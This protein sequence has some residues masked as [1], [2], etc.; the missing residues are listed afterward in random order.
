MNPNISCRK[1]NE[2]TSSR[3]L[4]QQNAAAKGTNS[5]NRVE[6]KG[7]QKREAFID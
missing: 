3:A 1:I 2:G 6:A 4:S 5:E 7:N